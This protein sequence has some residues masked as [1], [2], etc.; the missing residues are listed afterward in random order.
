[1]PFGHLASGTTT[2]VLKSPDGANNG[3]TMPRAGFILGLSASCDVTAITGGRVEF[4]ANQNEIAQSEALLARVDTNGTGQNTAG[5]YR[6]PIRFAAL[7]RLG[8][9][10]VVTG[11][12]TFDEIA[13][14]LE[15]QLDR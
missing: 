13:V 14:L 12:I 10:A 3:Y 15:V 9:H 1:L 4:R 5:L 2:V 8:A 6:P 11:I 7:E